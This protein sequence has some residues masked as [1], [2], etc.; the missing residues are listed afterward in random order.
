MT[1]RST[2]RRKHEPS[3][4]LSIPGACSIP[5]QRSVARVW[6]LTWL[7]VNEY[8]ADAEYLPGRQMLQGRRPALAHPAWRSQSL[9][10]SPET[11]GR[12]RRCRETTAWIWSGTSGRHVSVAKMILTLLSVPV[13][14][15]FP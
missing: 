11:A 10:L 14:S 7:L 8:E 12:L 9:V 4:A 15:W 2:C 1:R 3:T 13:S 5:F 6:T